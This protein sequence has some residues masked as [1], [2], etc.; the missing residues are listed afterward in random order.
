MD[1]KISNQDPTSELLDKLTDAMKS[2]N[3]DTAYQ[4]LSKENLSELKVNQEVRLHV[5]TKGHS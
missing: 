5:H 3:I 2:K 4:L 1:S